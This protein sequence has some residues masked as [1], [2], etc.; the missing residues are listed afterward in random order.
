MGHEELS[1]PRTFDGKRNTPLGGIGVPRD[2]PIGLESLSLGIDD[3]IDTRA[4]YI[5]DVIMVSSERLKQV[6]RGIINVYGSIGEKAGPIDTLLYPASAGDVFPILLTPSL[7]MVDATTFGTEHDPFAEAIARV[8]GH[9]PQP[10]TFREL[11]NDPYTGADT[12]K[13]L[14]TM[15]EHSVDYIEKYGLG[16]HQPFN[17]QY[18]LYEI[19]RGLYVLGVNPLDVTMQAIKRGYRLSFELDG[20]QKQISYS[21]ALLPHPM[22]G[23]QYATNFM[24]SANEGNDPQRTGVL[25]KADLYQVANGVLETFSPDVLIHDLRDNLDS[26]PEETLEL[27]PAV[28]KNYTQ[29]TLGGEDADYNDVRF[30]YTETPTHIV[31]GTLNNP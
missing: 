15:Q 30:G 17:A 6:R 27:Y 5:R 13:S 4:T 14:L 28:F 20:E 24:R 2:I 31:V 16:G 10:F 26:D 21:S 3:F 12:K 9:K 11:V 22:E 23:Y 7:I 29:E 8:D 1:P 19:M 25:V 18:S